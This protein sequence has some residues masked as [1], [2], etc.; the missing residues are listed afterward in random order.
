MYYSIV[1]NF[2]NKIDVTCNYMQN[3]NSSIKVRSDRDMYVM[4]YSLLELQ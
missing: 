4:A 2:S 3:Q 1:L